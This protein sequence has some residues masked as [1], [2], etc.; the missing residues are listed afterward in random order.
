MNC[1]KIITI[2]IIT[3][4]AMSSIILE[5]SAKEVNTASFTLMPGSSRISPVY[6]FVTKTSGNGMSAV[7][8]PNVDLDI[9]FYKDSIPVFTVQVTTDENGYYHIPFPITPDIAD[10]FN[11]VVQYFHYS[12]NYNY[13]GGHRLD[14]RLDQAM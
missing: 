14:I 5:I 12:P 2:V 7:V 4:I 3:I 13:T 6:G 11:V 9:N 8:A 1:K 10:E